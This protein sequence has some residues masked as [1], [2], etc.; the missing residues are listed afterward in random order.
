[1]SGGVISSGGGWF[2]VINA[3]AF[4]SLSLVGVIKDADNVLVDAHTMSAERSTELGWRVDITYWMQRVTTAALQVRRETH[5]NTYKHKEPL[6]RRACCPG[7][8][9]QGNIPLKENPEMYTLLKSDKTSIHYIT[10]L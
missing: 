2:V 7:A 4:S 1:M 9:M 8:S 3:Y 10:T 5:T 6:W